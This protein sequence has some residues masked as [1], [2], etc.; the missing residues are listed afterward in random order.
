[1]QILET[2]LNDMQSTFT[3]KKFCKECRKVTDGAVDTIHFMSF[4]RNKATRVNK[5]YWKKKESIT[6]TS[7]K[8]E[9]AI[10]LLKTNG[11]KVS[12]PYTEYREI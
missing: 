12:K 4:L 1:M 9:E 3:S 2:A 7:H 5:Y 10:L 8:I 11:F 6:S